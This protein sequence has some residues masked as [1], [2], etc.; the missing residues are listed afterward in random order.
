MVCF[1]SVVLYM[2][3]YFKSATSPCWLRLLLFL[4]VFSELDTYLLDMNHDRIRTH[5]SGTDKTRELQEN[6][7]ESSRE[8]PEHK[9]WR[10]CW[11]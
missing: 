10:M 3:I 8:E 7:S 5:I 1:F 11:K 2:V 4:T 9:V 6:I